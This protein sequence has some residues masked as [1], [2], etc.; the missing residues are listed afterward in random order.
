MGVKIR[1][2]SDKVEVV[3]A[4]CDHPGCKKTATRKKTVF[5]YDRKSGH[6][7]KTIR[8]PRNP[9]PYWRKVFASSKKNP[10]LLKQEGSWPEEVKAYCDAHDPPEEET[11]AEKTEGG[12]RELGATQLSL[13]PEPVQMSFF[14]D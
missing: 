3:V 13:F 6:D 8:E 5:G 7:R 10:F 4:R 2:G 12:T 11:V 9:F 1:K 14:E